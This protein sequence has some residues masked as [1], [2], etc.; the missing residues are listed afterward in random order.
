[1]ELQERKEDWCEYWLYAEDTEAGRQAQEK[2]KWFGQRWITERKKERSDW[3]AMPEDQRPV[4][5][6]VGW[7]WVVEAEV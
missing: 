2:R 5:P 7:P 4:H 1:M 3:Q 6:G